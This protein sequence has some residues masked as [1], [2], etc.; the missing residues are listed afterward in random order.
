M[1]YVVCIGAKQSSAA[2]RRYVCY[3]P[4]TGLLRAYTLI[5][6]LVSRRSQRRRTAPGNHPAAC[7]R[8]PSTEGIG[9]WTWVT[10]SGRGK[11]RCP[12]KMVR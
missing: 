8:H 4:G 1:R 7:G 6:C 11:V 9:V 12:Y 10:Q 3:A 2:V 5:V